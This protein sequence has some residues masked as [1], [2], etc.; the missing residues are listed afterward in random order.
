MQTHELLKPQKIELRE[1]K[2][3]LQKKKKTISKAE[4]ERQ[5]QKVKE[6]RSIQK[7]NKLYLSASRIERAK[8]DLNKKKKQ[9]K[10]SKKEILQ[11]EEKIKFF[12]S[13]SFMHANTF[14]KLPR[15]F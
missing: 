1:N 3:V 14:N 13:N 11:E 15:L 10:V 9:G 2:M 12:T 7:K 6:K 8:A 5:L 4:K